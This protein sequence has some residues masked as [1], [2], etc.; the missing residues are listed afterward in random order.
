MTTAPFQTQAAVL[1]AAANVR[2]HVVQSNVGPTSPQA[3]D[4]QAALAAGRG[5]IMDRPVVVA[6]LWT[7]VASEQIKAAA[8]MIGEADPGLVL[9]GMSPLLR[10]VVEHSAATVWVLDNRESAETRAARAAL[11]YL[12][13]LEDSTRAASHLGGRGNPSHLEARAQLRELR[14][15][16]ATE[17]PDGTN[18][19]SS[20]PV[21]AGERSPSPTDPVLHYGERWGTKEQWEGVYDYLCAAANHPNMLAFELLEGTDDLIDRFCQTM[22]SPYVKALQHYSDYCGFPRSDLDQ[23]VEMVQKTWPDAN[24]TK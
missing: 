3:V 20:P 4:K 21:I 11:Y 8:V 2:R 9:I 7:L 18:L 13:G 5:D 12:R 24:A 15:T 22:I 6:D 1:L 17:F 10:S 19:T 23:F 16:L 14:K